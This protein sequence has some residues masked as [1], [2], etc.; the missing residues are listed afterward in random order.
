M[1]KKTIRAAAHTVNLVA[2]TAMVGVGAYSIQEASAEAALRTITDKDRYCLQQNIYFE[3]RNQS[4]TGQVAVAWVTLNRM[5][6]DRYPD[7]ICGVVWQSKQ[8]SWTHDG[9]S[10]KPGKTVLEQ[11]A[12]ED[13]GLVAMVVLLDW[14]RERTSPVDNATMYHADYVKPYWRTSYNRVTQ[15]DNHIFYEQKG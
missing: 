5:E 11:R 12:W 1:I 14:A 10:D 4:T 9:K 6:A 8:F 7:T 2:F 15:I 3:A 13:A